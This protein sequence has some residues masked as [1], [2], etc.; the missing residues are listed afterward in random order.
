MISERM[1]YRMQKLKFSFLASVEE[2]AQRRYQ[3]K[4]RERFFFVRFRKK[5]KEEIALRDKLDSEREFAPLQKAEDA[6][7]LDTTSLSIEQV[8]EKDYGYCLFEISTI[9]KE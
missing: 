5:L 6:I 4:Y 9:R 7:E 8:V 1:S 3:E 2:R